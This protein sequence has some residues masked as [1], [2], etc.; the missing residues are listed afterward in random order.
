MRKKV[1]FNLSPGLSVETASG[2]H[3]CNF[4]ID[5]FI[6]LHTCHFLSWR[7]AKHIFNMQKAL[8]VPAFRETTAAGFAGPNS[9]ECEK[10]LQVLHLDPKYYLVAIYI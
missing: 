7:N 5:C 2:C 6:F 3:E 4:G 8:F 9:F 1:F 10:T